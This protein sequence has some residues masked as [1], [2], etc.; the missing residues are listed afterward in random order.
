MDL[1]LNKNSSNEYKCSLTKHFNVKNIICSFLYDL[2][3]IINLYNLNKDH[4][5]NIKI[6]NLYDIPEKYL[7]K[8]DQQIIEQKKYKFVEKLNACNNKK[9]KNVNHMRYTL[10]ILNC[11]WNCG[12]DQNGIFLLDLI[13]LY[14]TNNK[15]I[16][17]VNHMKRKL[18]ILYCCGDSAIDQKGIYE[19][20]LI[21]LGAGNNKKI[22]NVNHMKGALKILDCSWN[23]GINQNGISE[24]NLVELYAGYN[25]KI[26]NTNHMKHTLKKLYCNNNSGI[27]QKG[28]SDGEKYNFTP[29][30]GFF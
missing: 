22:N 29:S 28:I 26:N 18:K 6:T 7:K 14:A 15:K 9:I 13:E 17:N 21:K 19:L 8:L 30:H 2:K 24:L 27:D 10:K 4:Q 11:G 1:Q 25:K 3:D 16:N 12:I 5:N 23:C 20:N